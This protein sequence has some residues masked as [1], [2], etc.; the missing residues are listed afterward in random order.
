MTK[1]KKQHASRENVSNMDSKEIKQVK[2]IKLKYIYE[3]KMNMALIIS[4]K[5]W[6][7]TL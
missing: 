6:V 3:K 7:K 2:E 1:N 4:I 5:L